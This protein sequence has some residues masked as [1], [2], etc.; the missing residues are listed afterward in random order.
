MADLWKPVSGVFWS[1]APLLPSLES[2]GQLANSPFFMTVFGALAGAFAG[3]WAAQRIAG[4]SKLREEWQKE[5]RNTNTGIVL[6][7]TTCNLAYAL[8]KQHIKTMKESYDADCK[9]KDA[10]IE[11]LATGVPQSPLSVAPNLLSLH[12]ITPPVNTLQEIVLG[13]LS[14]TGRALAATTAVADAIRNL[15][16]VIEKR[17]NL[18]ERIKDER[19]PEGAQ[20]HHFYFGM[21]Y[22]EGK[23]NDEYGSYV[24][25]LALYTDDAIFFSIKLYDDLREHGLGIAKKYKKKF[26]GEVPGISYINWT[27][28]DQEGLLPEDDEYESW[29]SGYGASPQKKCSWWRL[30]DRSGQ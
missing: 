5:I 15:N 20:V 10:Y 29:L 9:E 24:K 12:E 22:A 13:R 26:G 8:K 27:K 16:N 17:N 14:T 28:A 1:T 21:P 4:R 11:R 18:I 2:I 23:S 7:S 6:T 30:R 3:A 25:A 19:L